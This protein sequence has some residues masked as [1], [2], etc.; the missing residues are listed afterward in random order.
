MTANSSSKIPEEPLREIRK[1]EIRL[2]D[3]LKEEETFVKK[4]RECIKKLR[5]SAIELKN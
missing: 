2:D 4:L 5:M 3:F 1:L